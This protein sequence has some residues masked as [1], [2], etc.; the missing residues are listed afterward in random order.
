MINSR[1]KNFKALL[2]IIAGTIVLI[3]FHFLGWLEPATSIVGKT[4][5]A[6]QNTVYQAGGFFKNILHIEDIVRENEKMKTENRN[7]ALNTAYLNLLENENS[8]I[9]KKLNFFEKKK[10]DFVIAQV[11]A[12]EPELNQ[13]IIIIN[14]GSNQGLKPGSPV[15]IANELIGD[16]NNPV[17]QIYGFIVGKIIKTNSYY[18]WVLLLTDN[19]SSVAAELINRKETYG[20]VRGERGLSLKIDLIPMGST[21]EIGDLA[22]TS[23]LENLIP[24]GLIIG[25]VEKIESQPEDFF[26]KAS[27][28]T[29][30]SFD[31]LKMVAIIIPAENSL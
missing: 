6:P 3:F 13:K 31:N 27:L 23:G 19:R 8:Q 18:S 25:E 5:N 15:V 22:V 2:L 9:R 21:I 30:I 14:Q 10:F 29:L 7:C 16:Q 1:K 11:V 4:F 24:E 28:D 20:L 17:P 26:Q 12:R